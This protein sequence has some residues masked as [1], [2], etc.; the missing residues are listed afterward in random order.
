MLRFSEDFDLKK[1]GWDGAPLHGPCVPA[2]MLRP[3]LF[4]GRDVHVA[5]ETGSGL[6]MGMSVV[7]W[8]R[9]TDRP[10]N[11]HYVR[12]CDADG[13]YALLTERVSRLP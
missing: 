7:D 10:A 1:Y 4:Q 5:I 13:Y 12:D 11:A 2:F 8:W 9:V 6:T 3:E